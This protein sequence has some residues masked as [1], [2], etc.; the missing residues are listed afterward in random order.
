M[1]EQILLAQR[2]HLANLLEAVQRC[3]FFLEGI[4]RK[5]SWPLA[6]DFLESN[7]KDQDLFESL[8]AMNER[9]AKL[10]DTLGAGMRH[11]HLLLGESA[12]NFLRILVAYEKWGVID[13]VETWQLCRTTR[14][15]AAHDYDIDYQDIANHFNTLHKLKPQL[16][17]AAINF[18]Q[19]CE[20]QLDIRPI[21]DDFAVEFSVIFNA[22]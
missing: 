22:D 8:A 1:T 3:V 10:Q 7:K 18:L 13:S 21:S 9:F 17:R 16:Y 19:H 6:C 20:T 2:M 15:L 12:D 5:I 14:N 4:D 11:A